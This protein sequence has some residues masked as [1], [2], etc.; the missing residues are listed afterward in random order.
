VIHAEIEANR[1]FRTVLKG[2]DAAAAF[3][4]APHTVRLSIRQERISAV[5][6]EARAVLASFDRT[7][8]QLTVWTSCQAPFRIRAEIA[9]LLEMHEQDVRVIAPD[10]VGGFGVKTGPYRE[11]VALAWLARRLGRPVKWV[12]TRR[13]DFETTNQARGSSCEAELALDADGRIR[14]LRASSTTS[15]ASS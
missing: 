6:M 7:T 3:A 11:D 1:P 10:V 12:S 15:G 14:G 4:G 13:E 8:G 2:G 9:R 5:A